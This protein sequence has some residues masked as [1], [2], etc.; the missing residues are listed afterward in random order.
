MCACCRTEQ[1]PRAVSYRLDQHAG[2][3]LIARMWKVWR[4]S[5]VRVLQERTAT[6]A[7]HVVWSVTSRHT[8][9]RC[10]VR[11]GRNV[12]HRDVDFQCRPILLEKLRWRSYSIQAKLAV[13]Y[14]FTKDQ[15]IR[16]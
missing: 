5:N 15:Y 14:I 16:G 3:K 8:G 11:K 6:T 12:S 7:A 4:R 2:K 9:S 13:G 10:L 1:Q